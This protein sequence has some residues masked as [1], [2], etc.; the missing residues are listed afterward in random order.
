MS[1]REIFSRW[2]KD[3]DYVCFDAFHAALTPALA[4]SA[5]LALLVEAAAIGEGISLHQFRALRDRAEHQAREVARHVR[6][7]GQVSLFDVYR[8]LCV[9]DPAL[10]AFATRLQELELSLLSDAFEAHPLALQSVREARMAGKTVGFVVESP[11]PVVA[12]A[13]ALEDKSYEI[14]DSVLTANQLTAWSRGHS[15]I[16]VG[17]RD[18]EGWKAAESIG[19]RPIDFP[20]PP[21]TRL[22]PLTIEASCAVGQARVEMLNRVDR[23]DTPH[24]YE[25][26]AGKG[27]CIFYG[28]LHWLIRRVHTS[29]SEAVLFLARDGHFLKD[30]YEQA[31]RAIW[32]ELPVANYVLA[33][34]RLLNIASIREIDDRT[35]SFLMSGSEQMTV[36][37]YLER[38]GLVEEQFA[39][40]CNRSGFSVEELVTSNRMGALRELFL[41]LA[42]SLLDAS[43]KEREALLEYLSQFELGRYKTIA[44]VDCGWHGSLQSSLE[45]LLG[46]SRPRVVGFYYGLFSAA[47]RLRNRGQ[48][49]HGFLCD[50]TSAHVTQRAIQACV[51]VLETIH[52]AP[53]GSVIKF[54]PGSDGRPLPRLAGATNPHYP[55]IRGLHMGALQTMIRWSKNAD[56]L[57]EESA[58]ALTVDGLRALVVDPNSTETNYLGALTHVD[59][60]CHTRPGVPLIPTTS[61]ASGNPDR[62]RAAYASTY[63]KFGFAA[64]VR[65]AFLARGLEPPNLDLP[66]IVGS[67]R[68]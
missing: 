19:W 6:R 31:A 17:R 61:I 22:A 20:A 29:G 66:P 24:L 5:D 23:G 27:A 12:C 56:L 57:S 34:R 51:T 30:V 32:P 35:L 67:S 41:S 45:A 60:F 65:D 4:S 1:F 50:D 59:S 16:Y 49:M 33:S 46:P 47:S 10:A 64:K 11:W 36:R 62:I 68:T 25:T 26:G 43:T 15:G 37:E 40:A 18:S 63:W 38:A 48:E 52:A 13:K 55:T 44:V 53:H 3:A 42:D 9:I 39:A 8:E 58:R 14:V 2:L 54:E 28:F 21:T 7:S